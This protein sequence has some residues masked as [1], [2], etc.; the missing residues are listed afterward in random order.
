VSYDVAIIGAGVIGLSCAREL[1]RRGRSVLLLERNARYG[2]ETSSRNSGVIHAGLYYPTGSV[3][4][5]L[6]VR[7]NRS[8]YQWCADNDVP[9]AAVGKYIVAVEP[10]EEAALAAIAASAQANGAG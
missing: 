1:G 3:K 6:C 9:F 2:E 4:A 8:L 7:G 5:E 10:S